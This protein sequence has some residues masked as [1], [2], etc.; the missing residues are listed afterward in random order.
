MKKL[1]SFAAPGIVGLIV[2]LGSLAQVQPVNVPVNIKVHAILVDDA[3]NQKPV[4]RLALVFVPS[5]VANAEPVTARTAST[6]LPNCNLRR[7]RI[8]FPRPPRL[9]SKGKHTPGGWT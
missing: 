6:G 9:N 8:D 2:C 4:P 3:L 1:I 7:E 5:G